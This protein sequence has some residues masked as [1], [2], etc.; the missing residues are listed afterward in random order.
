[1]AVVIIGEGIAV[2]GGKGR[3]NSGEVALKKERGHEA[4]FTVK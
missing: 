2:V 1:M 4:P 3:G